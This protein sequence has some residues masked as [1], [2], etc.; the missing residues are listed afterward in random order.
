MKA[1]YDIAPRWRDVAPH[2]AIA[3]HL[4]AGANGVPNG[5]GKMMHFD[6]WLWRNPQ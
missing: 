1:Q 6:A 3:P 5:S 4:F 2:S